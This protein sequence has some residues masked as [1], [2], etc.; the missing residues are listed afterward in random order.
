MIVTIGSVEN[1][2]WQP[3]IYINYSGGCSLQEVG[4]FLKVKC[5]NQDF[6]TTV[7]QCPNTETQ[8]YEVGTI[9]YLLAY[10]YKI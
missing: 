6:N 7:Y 3:I 8:Y 2:I 1:I 10:L 9:L 5:T 4:R